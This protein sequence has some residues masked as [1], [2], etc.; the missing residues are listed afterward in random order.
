VDT[1]EKASVLLA[2]I[3]EKL[4]PDLLSPEWR[5]R[6]TSAPSGHCYV[7][8]EALYYLLGGQKSPWRP[9]VAR[10]GGTTHW[11]LAGPDGVLDPTAAQF[12]S[13]FDYSLGRRCGFLTKHASKRAVR[14]MAR[15]IQQHSPDHT[16]APG[17]RLRAYRNLHTG[18]WSAVDTTT[19]RVVAHPQRLVLV[20]ANYVVRPAGRR[21][22]LA[23]GRKNV[24]A[25]VVGSVPSVLPDCED[26]VQVTYNPYRLETFVAHRPGDTARTA[27]ISE[28]EIAV[29]DENSNVYAVS[30]RKKEY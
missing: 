2:T 24:H 19:G 4:S 21:K 3:Q 14:L 20:D 8:S 17:V 7:A 11:W 26:L 10:Q 22:V 15:V 16:I 18:T 30:S 1:K 23:T 27:P 28:S 29:L 9:L 13:G 25:F 6:A 12:E 5:D